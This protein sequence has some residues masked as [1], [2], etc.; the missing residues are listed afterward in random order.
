MIL[1][2]IPLRKMD[3]VVMQ[4]T[5]NAKYTL[6]TTPILK[7]VHVQGDILANIHKISYADHDLMKYPE[8]QKKNDMMVV[9]LVDG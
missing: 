1:G 4:I 9:C 6:M 3:A 2:Y 8:F 7:G 5:K